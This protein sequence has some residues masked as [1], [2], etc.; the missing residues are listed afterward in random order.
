MNLTQED[1]RRLALLRERAAAWDHANALG[2]FESNAEL[3]VYHEGIADPPSIDEM[4]VGEDRLTL[5]K[6]LESSIGSES[7]PNLEDGPPDQEAAY[8]EGEMYST[9]TTSY[10]DQGNESMDLSAGPTCSTPQPITGIH[11]KETINGRVTQMVYIGE[12]SDMALINRLQDEFDVLYNMCPNRNRRGEIVHL[13]VMWSTPLKPSTRYSLSPAQ[14]PGKK[15]K[16]VQH[17]SDPE[18]EIVFVPEPTSSEQSLPERQIKAYLQ[19]GIEL[20]GKSAEVPNFKITNET[21]GF[22]DA[23]LKLLYPDTS[24]YPDNPV[25]ILEDVFTSTRQ[26]NKIKVNY[27]LYEPVLPPI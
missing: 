26:L 12:T 21:L 17:S 16:I 4:E 23:N 8:H 7:L 5:D 24:L 1:E 14:P 13:I 2:E 18:P 9:M 3:D 25:F 19:R 27:Q 22:S 10:M 20:K 6:I 15:R 11:H